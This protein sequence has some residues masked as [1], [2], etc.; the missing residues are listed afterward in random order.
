MLSR[1][2]LLAFLCAAFG[3]VSTQIA[4]AGVIDVTGSNVGDPVAGHNGAVYTVSNAQSAGTGTITS[5]LRLH[6]AGNENT[7]K[8]Y[9]VGFPANN[10][11]PGF[12]DFQ[13]VGGN[14]TYKIQL[15]TIPNVGGAAGFRRFLLD[16]NESGGN[17]SD[18][19]LDRLLLF[20]GAVDPQTLIG[21]AG[22]PGQ[23][24]D[25][26][27]AFGDR[28]YDQDFGDPTNSVKIRDRFPGSGAFD[29]I[30]DVPESFFAGHNSTEFVTLFADFGS[31]DGGFEEFAVRGPGGGP[32]PGG[33]GP[34]ID[35]P[36]IPE[37]TSL[38]V[39]GL[40]GLCLAGWRLARKR[41]TAGA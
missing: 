27:A 9:N 39:W 2:R 14:F 26:S 5:F 28:V 19:F 18:I 34:P 4:S 1:I 8:G 11:P 29:L 21:P 10:Y 17:N 41:R 37:P 33:S 23:L 25:P 20:V 22:D 15:G 30:I 13:Q 40:G 38:L 32:G 35:P 6:A 36:P 12:P 24:G 31:F 7:Q 16:L 3:V